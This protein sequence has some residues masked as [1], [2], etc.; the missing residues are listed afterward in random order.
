MKK[1]K[2]YDF[3]KNLKHSLS[4]IGNVSFLVLNWHISVLK[5]VIMTGNFNLCGKNQNIK[6]KS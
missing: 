3:I 1:I 4:L 5:K 2:K 6:P